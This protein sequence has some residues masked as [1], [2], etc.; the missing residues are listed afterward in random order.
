MWNVFSSSCKLVAFFLAHFWPRFRGYGHYSRTQVVSTGGTLSG[1]IF[2]ALRGS[3]WFDSD[4]LNL[5]DKGKKIFAKR[6]YVIATVVAGLCVTVCVCASA[7]VAPTT[8]VCVRTAARIFLF[9]SEKLWKSQCSV[10]PQ[11]TASNP[12]PGD[13]ERAAGVL[14]TGGQS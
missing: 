3:V 13:P 1:A 8:V 2:C 11:H 12:V 6:D 5:R 4:G 14:T 7:F 10:R 9:F